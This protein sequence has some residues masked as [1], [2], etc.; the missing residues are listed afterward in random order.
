MEMGIRQVLSGVLS[1]YLSGS[2]TNDIDAEI[3]NNFPK[4]ILANIP[5]S[6]GSYSVKGLAGMG[7]RAQVPL[8]C[9]FDSRVT[10]RAGRGYYLAYLFKTD[11]TGVYLSLN[12]AWEPFIRLGGAAIGRE[13]IS[14]MSER[15]RT[16]LRRKGITS[17]GM[18]DSIDLAHSVRNSN[19]ARGYERG[20]IFGLYYPAESLPDEAYLV[21][22]LENM[23]KLYAGMV[24][25]FKGS[26]EAD[27]LE[28]Y[29]DAIEEVRTTDKS[30]TTILRSLPAKASVS[31]FKEVEFPGSRERTR[32]VQNGNHR[33]FKPDY[34]LKQKRNMDIGNRGEAAAVELLQQWYPS[35]KVERVSEED[36]SLGYDIRV[37]GGTLEAELH[38]E[39]KATA[40]ISKHA[41]FFISSNEI[42]QAKADGDQFMLLRLFGLN[43]KKPGYYK[44]MGTEV[45]ELHLTPSSYLVEVL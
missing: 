42:E 32:K 11:M 34:M 20:H 14:K 10:N 29:E 36:D 1:R 19:L 45:A 18:R 37:T 21:A 16:V 15:V 27:P 24:D 22:D 4:V 7:R 3:R 8:L 13:T 12:Q 31:D 2:Q 44:V 43:S 25:I 9:I 39:V 17:T 40:E 28:A 38:V 41:Q 30:L 23:L 26:A 35:S 6:F 5:P 33:P